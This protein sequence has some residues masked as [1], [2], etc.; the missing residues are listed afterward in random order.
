[1]IHFSYKEVECQELFLQLLADSGI[2]VDR[3]ILYPV[4]DNH[5]MQQAYVAS[6]LGLFP[7]R[8]EGGNNMV[9]CE[10]M[11]SGRPVIA[12]TMTGHMDVINSGNAFCLTRYEPVL[13]VQDGAAM[14]VWFEPSVDETVALL[15]QAYN[16]RQLLLRVATAAGQSMK[17]LSW[18]R[19]AK[20]F[21]ALGLQ[22]VTARGNRSIGAAS[23]ETQPEDADALFDAGCY[24]EAERAYSQLLKSAPLD[25]DLHNNYGTVLDR[26]GR[27]AESVLHYEKALALRRDFVA[28]RFNLAN[29][30]K[31][32]GDTGRAITELEIVV[33]ADPQFVPAWQ[34][35]ALCRLD[36]DDLPGAVSCLERVLTIDPY[37]VRSNA[38]LGELLIELRRHQAAVACFDRALEIEPGNTGVLNSKGVALQWLN[39][40]DGAEA[41]YRRVLASDPDNSLALNNMGATMRSRALP[42]KAVEYFDRALSV[43]PDDGQILFNRSLALLLS[44]D[45]TRGWEGY[46]NRFRGT[47]PVPLRHTDIPRWRGE[48]LQGKRILVWC[49]Q[50]YG[51]SI[52]FVRYAAS[53]ALEGAQVLIEAQDERIGA[54]LAR[55]SGVSVV[56]ARDSQRLQADYQIPLLS[57]PGLLG[58]VPCPPAYLQLEAA[59]VD[60][61]KSRLGSDG[62]MNIGLAWAGRPAHENDRNRS[63]APEFFEPL[64]L[65]TGVR[66]ISLQ[67]SPA[68]QIV[69]PALLDMCTMVNDFADSAA[70]VAGLDLVI[71]V[72][73]AVAHLAGA[74][75]VPVWILLPYNP[76]WRWGLGRSDTPWYSSARLFRQAA[77]FEWQPVIAMVVNELKMLSEEKN[78]KVLTPGTDTITKRHG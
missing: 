51:D 46:E 60:T 65:V 64:S 43:T 21:H 70:L 54:L 14:G 58:M 44:G 36:S 16:D 30:L 68:K 48:N 74:L 34:N 40:L 18:V 29:T 76:D 12:S 28:A 7:N 3:V 27:Y 35:L 26:L 77:P 10:Y 49:E 67:F 24:V 50:G 31:R 6:D 22:L 72:D 73:S 17:A 15:E 66:F 69:R 13:A 1:M 42:G 41:C 61:W 38:D 23:K 11:A 56:I 39:D 9:M 32:M 37:C 25:P 4:L 59:C 20:A 63:I 33:T 5:Q 53:L 55:A 45:F 62:V 75:G 8:C 71:S 57:L 52:Q 2:P 78:L 19:A 47:P